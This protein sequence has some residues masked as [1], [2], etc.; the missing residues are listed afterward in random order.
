MNTN[1][2]HNFI[3]DAA[4][5]VSMRD[6]YLVRLYQQYSLDG[7]YVFVDKSRCS[8]IMQKRLAVDTIL[9]A[10]QGG[11]LCI[12]E[13][14]ERWPGYVRPNFALETDSC[15]VP[16]HEKQGWMHYARA[17]YLLYAFEMEQ[18]GLDVYLIDFPAL[19]EWFWPIH[20]RYE[21][22]TMDTLNRTQFRKVPIAD[23]ARAVWT[24][25]Y[26][27]TDTH[28]QVLKRGAA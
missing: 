7:R 11:S 9:Q 15:T 28:C 27:I 17:D 6:R 2:A 21:S 14:I 19:R 10:K 12:E 8:T 5:S 25:R 1:L 4:W 16:G 23:V 20:E 22:H 18:G 3:D 24:K 26:I 13:K